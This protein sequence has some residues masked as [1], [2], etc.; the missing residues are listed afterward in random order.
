MNQPLPNPCGPG[1]P[2]DPGKRAAILGA[3]KRLFPRCGF[4]G[5]SMDAIAAEAG[6]SKL[7][8]YS[9][10]KDKETLFVAAIRARCEEQM[11]ARLFDVEPGACES[12][13]GRLEAI[14]HAFLALVTAPEAVALNRLLTSATGASPKLVQLFWDAGP[15][16]IQAGFQQFLRQEVAAGRLQI[17]DVARA[18]AQFFALLKGELHARLLCGCGNAPAAPDL[19]AHVRASVEMFLRAYAPHPDRAVAL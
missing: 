1:R 4:E 13:R 18:S 16:R 8:V 15:Q 2:K 7:T 19:A 9:H 6:V 17:G 11:P 3:A 12:L 14:G 10:F 5:T